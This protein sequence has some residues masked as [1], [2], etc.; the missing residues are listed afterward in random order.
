MDQV[1]VKRIL[2]IAYHFPPMVGSSGMQR[3]LKFSNY[4]VEHGW[5]PTVL[6][7]S[8]RAYPSS[9]DDQVS[10]ILDSVQVMRIWAL[11][12]ARHLSIRGRYLD[13][14]A[15]PDRWSSWSVSA[16]PAGLVH[17]RRYRP[18]VI[19]STYPIASAHLIAY[20]LH[21]MSGIPWVADF[22]DMM[23]DDA[24]PPD[25]R[26]RASFEKIEAKTV[27]ACQKVVV[28]TPGTQNLYTNRYSDE[29]TDKFVCIRNGYDE[30]NFANAETSES[31]SRD[32]TVKLVHSGLLHPTERD[33]TSFF[34]ALAALKENG[35]F[36]RKNVQF[37]FRA[38]G[39]DAHHAAL[40]QKYEINDLVSLA[41]GIPYEEAL[42]EML[43]AQGLLIFQ[44]ANCNNQIPAKLYE[45]FRAGR[46]ILALTDPAGDTAKTMQSVGAFNIA[47]IDDAEE[48]KT[49]LARFI[50]NLDD[51]SLDLRASEWVKQYSRRAQA[52]QFADVLDEVTASH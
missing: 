25:P 31:D 39:N 13:I 23:F 42:R 41:P 32:S 1:V 11:D 34:V 29:S 27:S 3:T 22:R 48:I 38:T 44:A 21:R 28:T 52:N 51:N 17:I 9:R 20:W 18:S 7:V 24:Y 35:F 4:I 43:S 45:Y 12:A 26:M 14:L 6:T 19:W 40:L 15:R 49:M 36:D 5:A 8:P 16:I 46:P 30:E 47:K 33:P 2:M 10:E 37:V 50:D